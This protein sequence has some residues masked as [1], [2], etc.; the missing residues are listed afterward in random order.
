MK[1]LLSLLLFA[2]LFACKSGPGPDAIDLKA[3]EAAI[4]QVFETLFTAIDER[5]L[6]K[7]ASVLADDGLFLGTDPEE[8][9]PKDSMVASWSLM[10]QMPEIPPL[11]YINEPLVRI[12]PDGKTA[13][14]V[15][16][17]HWDLFTPLPL[18]QSFWMV[19]KDTTWLID[20]F[21]FSFVPENELIPLLNASMLAEGE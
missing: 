14:V 2:T 20:F 10:M 9:F 15:L 3:E 6:E 7:F 17:F 18:R 21:D 8:Q 19:K 4:D 16:Q 11:E 5:N 13:V 1:K 12:Q